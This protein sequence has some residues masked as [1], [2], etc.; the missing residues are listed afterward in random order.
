VGAVSS[1]AHTPSPTEATASA[2][3]IA[4]DGSIDISGSGDDPYGYA[5]VDLTNALNQ[6]GLNLDGVV[7]ELGLQLG[8]VAST[9]TANNGDVNSRYAVAGARLAWDAPVLDDVTTLITEAVGGLDSTVNGL[10]GPEGPVQELLNALSFDEID[11]NLGGLIPV[12]KVNLGTPELQVQVGL[13]ELVDGLIGETLV[14]DSGVTTID[15]TQGQIYIDLEA[16]HADGLNNL[17]ANTTLLTSDEITQITGEVSALLG[18]L[19]DSVTSSLEDSL[20]ETSVTVTLDP[21]ISA[22]G[23]V[24]SGDAEIKIDTT[25]AEL[26][27]DAVSEDAVTISGGLS[28]LGIPI[29]LL[30]LVGALLEPILNE[31]VPAITGPLVSELGNLGSLVSEAL[32]G[33]LDPVVSSLSPVLEALNQV[34][35]ITVNAQSQPGDL[36]EGSFSVSALEVEVLPSISAVSLPLAT[37]SVY[38]EEQSETVEITSPGEG[39]TVTADTIPVTGTSEPEV[40][41]EVT[42]DGTI[43]TVFADQDGNWSTEFDAVEPGQYTVTATD[44]ATEDSV[45]FTY[46][47]EDSEDDNTAENTEVN[48]AENTED[49]TGD[50]TVD[51]AEVNTAENTEVNTGDN[52]EVN[53]EVNTGDNTEVNTSDNTV[54]N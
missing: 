47:V 23:G 17:D 22:L 40:E 14:S 51:N 46:A 24:V 27:G 30:D 16:L 26:L 15:L 3:V 44:G 10:L 19:L 45:T 4:Q 7:D 2:G 13:E 8:A 39:E 52:T 6:L 11:V 31:V 33:V 18:E 42:L 25:I 49:N 20:G 34:A 9:A 43:N 1:Y 50:N 32:D 21:D 38:A 29:P 54:D 28:V 36:G 5:T 48:T 41:V 37:S 12:L 53:T 35:T